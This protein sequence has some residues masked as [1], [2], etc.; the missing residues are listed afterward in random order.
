M[1][2]STAYLFGRLAGRQFR[3]A[4]WMWDSV[5]GSDDDA[6]R[7]QQGLGRDMAAAVREQA[8]GAVDPAVQRLLDELT[9]TLADRVR[10]PAHRFE[11][12]AAGGDHPT[13][14]ALPGGY[15]F[16]APA[17]VE[18]TG[19]NRDELAFVIG[20]EM[21]H[22]IRGHVIDRIKLEWSQKA[23]SAV[24]LATPAGR[25]VAPW[26]RRVGVQWLE[27]AY[28]REQ[29]FEADE[30]GGRLMRA[31]GFD[32]HGCVR[33]L[34]RFRRLERESDPLGLAAYLSTHPPVDDRK[35]HLYER[36]QLRGPRRPA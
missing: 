9:A 7:A 14:F 32:P 19:R 24:S 36:L 18:L 4:K 27:K 10:N 6:I 15:I 11:V 1:A 23:L 22:V 17:L 13:A 3:K 33:M 35:H 26:L 31:A 25:T 30:L 12:G 28:S 5:A 34:E 2:K 21:A 8:P 16:V 29:E 20:H